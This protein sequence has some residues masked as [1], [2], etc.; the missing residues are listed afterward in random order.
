MKNKL[1]VLLS[2]LAVC[3]VLGATTACGLFTM[4]DSTNSESSSVSEPINE[5]SEDMSSDAASDSMSDSSV[6]AP[7]TY[8]VTFM[9]DGE[10]VGTATY[11]EDNTEITEPTVPTKEHYT[12]VWEA[13][14]LTTGDITV[15]AVYTAVEYAITFVADGEEVT[16]ADGTTITVETFYEAEGEF[17]IS[18]N[19]T[20]IGA[21]SSSPG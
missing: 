16:V 14:E 8:T 5:S 15:N 19:D 18:V 3:S 11:T 21:S 9:A 7:T 1:K 13:Y 6:V 2:L 4:D 17:N 20:V 10:E 12:G